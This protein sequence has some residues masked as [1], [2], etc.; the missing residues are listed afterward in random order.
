M[1]L[2]VR[3]TR[4]ALPRC[5]LLALLGLQ[6]EKPVLPRGVKV[7]A[8]ALEAFQG[9]FRET[10]LTDAVSGPAARFLQVGLGKRAEA[11]L[12]RLR[13]AAAIAVKKAE[14]V[15]AARL[16]LWVDG[17]V[18]A[19]EGLTAEAAAQALAEGA[20]LGSYALRRFKTKP[21]GPYLGEVLLCGPGA[22]FARGARQGERVA[23]A[24]T[25]ARELQDTPANLMRPRDLV[26]RARALARGSARLSLRVLDERA[27]E[28]LGMG[29]FHSVARGSEEPA[30]LIHLVHRPRGGARGRIALVG[31]GLTFDAGGISLK[32]AA[33][34]EEM[35]YDMSGGAAVLGVFQA[36]RERELPLE[37]HGVIAA[38]ENLP[39]G[40]ANKP[41][42]LVTAMNGTTIEV[43]NTDA[44]GRLVLADAL[45][46]AERKAK[47]DAL[48]DLATLTGAV[49]TALGHELTGVLGNDQRL[50]DELVASG[51]ATGELV[52]PLPLLEQHKEH[53]KGSVGDLKNINAG[54]G[55]GSSAGAAFLS[56]FVGKTPWAHLDIAGTAWGADERDYQGGSGGTGVGVRLLLHWLEQRA[57]RPRKE[58]GGHGGHARSGLGA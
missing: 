50:S 56:Y 22:A 58:R 39:D 33:K 11:D 9:E 35:K 52:W 6:G 13:R 27:L 40:R 34:M 51:K 54:Q 7:P 8:L 55:A 4:V 20:V 3:D 47:P 16:V 19:L 46:Y 53:M 24:N 42:D 37:V 45:V 32:P 29:A 2:L 48:V 25:F 12:E 17:R 31:K 18:T 30:F 49:V 28:R 10:R 43:L 26:A 21:K 15:R 38:T 14:K 23:R 1:K 57:A 41:G 36:L 5:D 44:E